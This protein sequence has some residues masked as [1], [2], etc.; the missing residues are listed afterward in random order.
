MA[1]WAVAAPEFSEWGKGHVLRRLQGATDPVHAEFKI[2]RKDGQ[3]RWIDVSTALVQYEGQPSGVGIVIDITERKRAEMELEQRNRDLGMLNQVSQTLTTTLDLREVTE[4]LMIALTETIGAE[5]GSVWLWES[6]QTGELVCQTAYPDPKR[7]MTNMHLRPG[8]GVA[9]WVAQNGK[10]AVV[11]R[12]SSDSHFS[13]AIDMQTGFRTTSVLA[14]PLRVHDKVI[15]VLEAVNKLNGDF[16]EHD[17]ILV[18]TLATS[19]AIAIENARLVETLRRQTAE[20]EARNEE[21]DAFAHTA[22]HDL[23]SP[24]GNIVGYADLLEQEYASLSNRDRRKSLHII[25]QSG[26][27]MGNIVDEL[28]LLAGVRQ[29]EAEIAPLDMA[30]IVAEAQQRLAYMIEEYQAEITLPADW[31]VAMGHAP[32]VEE[33]WTNYLSNALKYG[34]R[35][36]RVELGGETQPDGRVRFWVRDNGAG[37]TPEAQANLFTPFARLDQARARGSGLGLSIVQRIMEKLGGQV[38]VESGGALGQGSIFYFA[39]PSGPPNPQASEI[40]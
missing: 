16:D 20:L 27:K 3:E 30:G 37:V 12:V 31:P 39:L 35:P 6:E 40:A 21:L 19:A 25:A 4:R 33:V 5:G 29:T 36:P 11:P 13:L 8:E 7:S 22:A 1:P 17:C 2:V 9:G 15:G 24:L 14:V 10:R 28:L 34:G 26:R 32:W 23:K 38:G 18:E